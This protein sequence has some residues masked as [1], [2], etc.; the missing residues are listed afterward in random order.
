[1]KK[2]IYI[3]ILVSLFAAQ[4]CKDQEMDI[5][6]NKHLIA[7]VGTVYE[8]TPDDNPCAGRIVYLSLVFSTDK[9]SVSEIETTS[10]NE[11]FILE[12]GSYDWTLLETK[13][14]MI[15]FNDG[16]L[17]HTYADTIFL[18]LQDSGIVGIITHL[19]ATKTKHVFEEKHI[20]NN[21]HRFKK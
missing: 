19:N 6:M 11:E 1:M 18:E 13:E 4:A 16:N 17:G 8:E 12:M 2:A 7:E 20:V 10:C 15:D 3:P 5:Y 9:V 14:I 21:E